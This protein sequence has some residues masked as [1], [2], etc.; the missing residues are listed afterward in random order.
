[1]I[2]STLVMEFINSRKKC[3]L[4]SYT[5]DYSYF[6]LVTSS[7]LRRSKIDKCLEQKKMLQISI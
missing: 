1:M 2:Y 6:D 3:F 4:Y 5:D 7:F